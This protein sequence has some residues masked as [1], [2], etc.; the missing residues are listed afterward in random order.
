[1]DDVEELLPTPSMDAF[2]GVLALVPSVLVRAVTP[3][4]AE[5]DTD[6]ERGG[7]AGSVCIRGTADLEAVLK[8][9]FSFLIFF[10][11]LHILTFSVPNLVAS[12]HSLFLS[13]RTS[14]NARVSSW[15]A[16]VRAS[17]SERGR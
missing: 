9:S 2:G 5:D 3:V 6:G 1:M 15:F 16:L 17:A 12:R 14:S 11:K 13:A 4:A 7:L 10:I 8:S